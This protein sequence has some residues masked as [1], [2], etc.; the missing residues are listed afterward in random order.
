MREK[1]ESNEQTIK[2]LTNWIRNSDTYTSYMPMDVSELICLFYVCHIFVCECV[3]VYDVK[4]LIFKGLAPVL[5][6][7]FINGKSKIKI[8]NNIPSKSLSMIE[9]QKS[10]DFAFYSFGQ[11][12]SQIFCLAFLLSFIMGTIF[13]PKTTLLESIGLTVVGLFAFVIIYAVY[14]MLYL[15]DHWND[16]KHIVNAN[17]S[18]KNNTILLLNNIF[19]SENNTQIRLYSKD[20][21]KSRTLHTID[22]IFIDLNETNDNSNDNKPVFYIIDAIILTKF[23][24]KNSLIYYENLCNKFILK[25]ILKHNAPNKTFNTDVKHILS[26]GIKSK[27]YTYLIV[28]NTAHKQNISLWIWKSLFIILTIFPLSFLYKIPLMFYAKTKKVII[29]KYLHLDQS[30][31][32]SRVIIYQH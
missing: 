4:I 2:I 22:D 9:S 6:P 26:N 10:K 23:I 7:T 28:L 12:C 11:F 15:V 30:F 20:Y 29:T 16:Y 17:I 18:T 13:V 27:E 21:F 5:Q 25:Y 14:Y 31:Q 1:Q 3:C 19:I 24:D 32:R 8:N